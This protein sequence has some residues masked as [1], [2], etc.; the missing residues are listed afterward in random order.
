MIEGNLDS[1]KKT[2]LEEMDKMTSRKSRERVIS[3][4]Y[5]QAYR[6]WMSLLEGQLSRKYKIVPIELLTQK[7]ENSKQ[8]NSQSTWSKIWKSIILFILGAIPTIGIAF[9]GIYTVIDIAKNICNYDVKLSEIEALR[10]RLGMHTHRKKY[11]SKIRY[12]VFLPEYSSLSEKLQDYINLIAL[13]INEHYIT[14]TLLVVCNGINEVKQIDS[15]CSYTLQL[16]K[17]MVQEWIEADIDGERIVETLDIVGIQYFPEI[18]RILTSCKLDENLISA[19]IEVM[20]DQTLGNGVVDRNEFHRFLRMCS[21]LFE[22][23]FQKDIEENYPANDISAVQLVEFALTSNLLKRVNHAP[24]YCFIEYFIRDYYRDYSKYT[25]TSEK[26]TSLFLYLKN[27]YPYQYSDIALLS[28]CVGVEP[29]EAESYEI[30]AW[31]HDHDAISQ[32]KKDK[33]RTALVAHKCGSRYLNLFDQYQMLTQSDGNKLTQDCKT[34]L[35]VVE[36]GKLSPEAKCCCLNLIS[37]ILFELESKIEIFLRIL[38]DYFYAFT[39][40]KIFS[41]PSEKNAEYIVDALLLSISCELPLRYRNSIERLAKC[42][43]IGKNIPEK[44]RIRFLR[45]GNVLFEPPT[46]HDYTRMA[47]EQSVDYPYEHILS[48]INYSASLLCLAQYA[49]A[50][51]ILSTI[52]FDELQNRNNNTFF[53]FIN[54]QIIARVMS[55]NI[56]RNSAKK[57]F[58]RLYKGLKGSSFS[59]SVIVQNNYAASIVFCESKSNFH[60]A[61]KILLSILQN[62]DD[63]HRFFAT[64]NLIVLYCLSGEKNKLIGLQDSIRVPYLLRR[65]R[66]FFEAKFELLFSNFE[67]CHTVQCIS[68]IMKPLQG[69]FQELNTTFFSLPV[70]WGVIERWFE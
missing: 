27:K 16:D 49:E 69:R 47:Y 25:F 10:K 52:V 50:Q 42:I 18:Q 15:R 33:L 17:D 68:D 9:S 39:D 61:E 21:L 51:H 19:L 32:R 8:E 43:R 62:D 5:S 63:Y 55:G 11:W 67:N 64:H 59:D 36:S 1:I 28:R 3:V 2:F 45:L 56:R 7:E 46:G 35:Y 31:Y 29:W 12:V 22:P 38:D 20:I 14:N 57:K 30:I 58:E 13:F 41:S 4:N 54:N 23:F 37:S 53:S 60:I 66:S 26:Y 34:M 44:K 70:L 65:Y 24:V 40:L 6:K 48:A